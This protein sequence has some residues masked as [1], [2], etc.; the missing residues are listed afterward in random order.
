MAQY[1][2]YSIVRGYKGDDLN[3]DATDFHQQHRNGSNCW[4]IILL[5]D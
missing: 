3:D 4:V 5:L 2:C 1:C